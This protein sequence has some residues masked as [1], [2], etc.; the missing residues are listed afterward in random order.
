[1]LIVQTVCSTAMS[2]EVKLRLPA[3]LTQEIMSFGQMCVLSIFISDDIYIYTYIIYIYVY[4]GIIPDSCK[5]ADMMIC[6]LVWCYHSA[7]QIVSFM[8]AK[9]GRMY[10][11]TCA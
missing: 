6:L 8:Y 7:Y 11:S 3:T 1:M 5:F 10:E 4:I 2:D 9:Y